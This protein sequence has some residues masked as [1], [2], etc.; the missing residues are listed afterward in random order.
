MP[1]SAHPPTSSTPTR[2]RHVPVKAL[3]TA[4]AAMLLTGCQATLFA[5]MNGVSKSSG[6]VAKRGIVYDAQ[7]QLK[8]D[9]YRP[10]G[11]NVAQGERAPVVVFFYGG[12]WKDGKRQWYRWVGEALARRGLV[13]V[14]PTYREYPQVKLDGFMTDAAN[15]VGWAYAHAAQ[16]GGDPQR[17]FLMGHSAGG[18]IAALLATNE[19]WLATVDMHPRQLDGF[20][21]LAGPYDFLPLKEQDYIDMFGQTHEQQLRS[22]PVHYVNGN[23][24]PMLLLQGKDDKIVAPK[25]ARSMAAALRAQGEPVQTKFYPDIGHIMLLLSMSRPFRSKADT[26]QDAVTWIK[27]HA[28]PRDGNGAELGEK[29]AV[30]P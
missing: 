2:R 16:F 19:K 23:E 18:Q 20:V 9:V 28:V 26:L 22:Q 1:D 13:A 11:L 5:G 15:A 7:H 14:L 3:L 8:L 4:M 25:N 21:G 12:S 6:V 17:M 24:P 29:A 30:S 27:A 10:A